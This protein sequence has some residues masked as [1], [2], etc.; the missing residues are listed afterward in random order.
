MARSG[1]FRQKSLERLS[2]PERLDQLLQVADRKNWIPLLTVGLLILGTMGWAVIAEVPVTVEGKGI[3]MRPRA[4]RALESPGPGRLRQ[5]EVGVGDVVRKGQVLGKIDRPDLEEQ[6][7]LHKQ[8]LVQLNGQSAAAEIMRHERTTLEENSA[9][10]QSQRLRDQIQ[11][12]R[13]VATKLHDEGQQAVADQAMRLAEQERIVRSLA[14]A[15]K[16]RLASYRE[17]YEEKII[18]RQDVDAVETDY[19]ESIERSYAIDTEKSRLQMDRLRVEEDFYDRL[20]EID[21]MSFELHGLEL[22]EKALAQENLESATADALQIADV[23]REIVR[24]E[25]EYREQGEIV[26]KHRGRILELNAVPGAVLGAGDRLGTL[27]VIDTES[28]LISLTYFRVRDGKRLEPGQP[29][30]VTPDTVE[31]ERYG[32]IEGVV[33]AVSAFPVTPEEAES[34]IGNT[35]VAREL[36]ADGYLIQVRSTLT[37]IPE[38]PGRFV[39]TSSR[40]P[41]HDVSAG[42]TTTA[43]AASSKSIGVTSP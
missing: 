35:V 40:G 28:P 9:T 14:K 27:E 10:L 2:S 12:S 33:Q 42:T 36:I 20:R 8:K 23:E 19:I 17:L 18:S 29:I 16:E 4:V 7:R 3:L 34:L 30:R 25:A 31:R 24:L 39:W 15:L 13:K 11:R 1:M 38:E 5:L 6:L 32:S 22:R 21:K 26:S 41:N 43:R 37:E